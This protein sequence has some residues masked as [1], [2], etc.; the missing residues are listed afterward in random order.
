MNKNQPNGSDEVDAAADVGAMADPTENNAA[1]EDVNPDDQPL[2]RAEFRKIL[3]EVS[4]EN[5][6]AEDA[7]SVLDVNEP[8]DDPYDAYNPNKIADKAAE[9][10]AEKTQRI[11]TAQIQAQSTFRRTAMAECAKELSGFEIPVDTVSDAIEKIIATYP[12]QESLSKLM[13]SKQYMNLIHAEVGKLALSGKLTRREA[14]SPEDLTPTNSGRSSLGS[15][16][17]AE[18]KKLFGKEPSA[19][20]ADK[21][22]NIGSKS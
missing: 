13:Q 4:T 5:A 10:A 8:E 9:I 7:G 21:V 15:D 11:L 20:I 18:F 19:A 17:V 12:D 14:K 2:T 1:Q 16:N 22:R 6:S 3:N